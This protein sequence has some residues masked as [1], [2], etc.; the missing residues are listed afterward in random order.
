[1]KT[2]F[3][4]S[5]SVDFGPAPDHFDTSQNPKFDGK[6]LARRHFYTDRESPLLAACVLRTTIQKPRARN[7]VKFT[8]IPVKI[9]GSDF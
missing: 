8:E 7:F 2:M 1:M 5:A 3:L 9:F 6:C 4:S